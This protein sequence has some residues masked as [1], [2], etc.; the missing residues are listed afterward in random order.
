M[1][2]GRAARITM[3][4]RANCAMCCGGRGNSE[5]PIVIRIKAW[6]ARSSTLTFGLGFAELYNQRFDVS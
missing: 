4:S 5:A 3:S 2:G 1:S 6:D